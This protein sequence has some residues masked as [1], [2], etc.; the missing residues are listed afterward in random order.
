MEGGVIAELV[1]ERTRSD[2]IYSAYRNQLLT[3]KNRSD[4]C[5]RQTGGVIGVALLGAL[6][7]EP[8]TWISAQAAQCIVS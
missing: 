1:Q 5:A 4:T 6:L 3:V 7:G 2:T 8:A